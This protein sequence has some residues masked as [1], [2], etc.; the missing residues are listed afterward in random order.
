MHTEDDLLFMKFYLSSPLDPSAVSEPAQ[1]A[2]EPVFPAE[3]LDSGFELTEILT[4]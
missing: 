2:N 4:S 1:T 3:L